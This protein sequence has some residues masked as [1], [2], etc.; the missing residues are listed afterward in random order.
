MI[1]TATKTLKNGKG[2]DYSSFMQKETSQ[3]VLTAREYQL[4]QRDYLLHLAE[5]IVYM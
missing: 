5:Q 2:Q 1:K 4:S 3:D